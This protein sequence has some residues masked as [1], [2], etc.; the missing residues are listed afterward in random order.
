MRQPGACCRRL[1]C[2]SRFFSKPLRHCNNCVSRARAQALLQ[3]PAGLEALLDTTWQWLQPPQLVVQPTPCWHW[4]MRNTLRYCW[5]LK[6]RR[7]CC[8]CSVQQFCFRG[9]AICAWHLFGDG[10]QPPPTA[11]GE[12]NAR[13]FARALRASGLTIV[14]GLALGVD[15]AAHEGA[16]MDAQDGCDGAAAGYR[17]RWAEQG[18]PQQPP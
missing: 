7:P 18:L 16:L 6:T 1:V 4:A 10:R 9:A 5:R 8:I 11:Q 12:G 15:A 17:R 2:H 13:Q 3:A 14:S